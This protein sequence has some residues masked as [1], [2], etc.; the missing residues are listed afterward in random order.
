MPTRPDDKYGRKLRALDFCT[1]H[2]D[3]TKSG[4]FQKLREIFP[5]A[6]NFFKARR[7]FFKLT[8]FQEFE[9]LKPR[10]RIRKSTPNIATEVPK[11]IQ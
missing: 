4:E 2:T 10:I 11:T 6:A 7:Q 5:L 8:Y 9:S 1:A 3:Q